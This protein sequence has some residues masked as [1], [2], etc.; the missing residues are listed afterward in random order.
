MVVILCIF[1]ICLG[2]FTLAICLMILQSPKSKRYNDSDGHSYNI[3]IPRH[4]SIY[5][6]VGTTIEVMK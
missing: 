5:A 4:N 2:V 6:P 3:Y 1:N